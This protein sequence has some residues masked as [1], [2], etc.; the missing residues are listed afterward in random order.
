MFLHPPV[1][2]VVRVLRY[3]AECRAGGLLVVP[4]W[5]GAIYM[6]KLRAAESAGKVILLKKF[7]PELVSPVW[8]KSRTF[9]GPARFDFFVYQLNF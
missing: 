9:H 5:P 6:A 1:G 2:L 4:F 7:R 3:A 8:V